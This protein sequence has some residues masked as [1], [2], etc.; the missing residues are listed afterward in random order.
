M[1]VL[2]TGAHG[3][4]GSAIFRAFRGTPR[5]AL[6]SP[7]GNTAAIANELEQPDTYE[8]RAD[9]GQPGN[10]AELVAHHDVVI[11]AAARATDYGPWEAFQQVNVAGTQQLARAA[12]AA[13]VRRFV[14]IS[15]VAVHRYSGFTNQLAHTVPRNEDRYAYAR[16]KRLAED[17]LWELASSDFEVVVLRPGLWP[18]GAHDPSLQRIVRAMQSGWFPL[19]GGGR[20][21]LNTVS[22][23]TFAAA[24][25]Q[26]ATVPAAAQKTWVISDAGMPT[27]R[28]VFAVIAS[29]A[30]V[31]APRLNIPS[32]LL[33]F[34]ASGIEQLY[35][36]LAP[37]REPPLTRYRAYLMRNSVH[38]DPAPAAAALG[39][40]LLP[41]DVSLRAS[42]HGV[43]AQ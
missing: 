43:L 3:Y 35:G 21:H 25:R 14:F 30:G 29:E 13:G 39:Y 31:A 18:H 10:L 12:K 11:H 24:T 42:V 22:A 20:A 16:S 32:W 8:V 41:W 17:A 26:A 27:W 7:W 1:R 33:P 37:G 38:F 6:I 19:V 40:E 28:N 9:L 34:P 2:I 4:L 36:L 23:T 5:T 15:T